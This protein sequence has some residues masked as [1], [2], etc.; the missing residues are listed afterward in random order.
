MISALPARCTLLVALSLLTGCGGGPPEPVGV[1]SVGPGPRYQPSAPGPDARPIGDLTCERAPAAGYAHVELFAHG[2]VV[3]VP[4]GIGLA[5]PRV[6][7]G[8]YVRGRG[9]R[10]PLF[11]EEPT[12][13]IGLRRPG[14]TLADLFRVWG[15]PLGPGAL[16]GFRAPVRVHVDGEPWAGDPGAVP[17]ERHGQVVVQAGRPLVTPHADYRFPPGH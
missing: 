7:E 15:R 8:A 10:Y 2:R 17:L 11:T 12:G 4:A 6:R 3:I 5:P 14:L 9:C 13:L 1:A 16:A